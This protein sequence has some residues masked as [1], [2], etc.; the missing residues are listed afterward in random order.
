MARNGMAPIGGEV[1][2]GKFAEAQGSN[3]GELKE[4]LAG[5]SAQLAR[6]EVMRKKGVKT[7]GNALAKEGI[8][9]VGNSNKLV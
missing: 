4:M 1:D 5:E 7:G 8:V 6:K 9:T 3:M 2:Y